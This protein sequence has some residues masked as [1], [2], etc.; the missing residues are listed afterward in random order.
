MLSNF[1]L[2][3]VI[4]ISENRMHVLA[5][6]MCAHVLIPCLYHR[7]AGGQAGRQAGR[8]VG[9]QAG[10]QTGRQAGRQ[11]GTMGLAGSGMEQ[12]W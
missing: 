8:Q 4:A 5:W 1:N 12:Q 7:L 10:T 9:R 11:A 6:K 3:T 2:G